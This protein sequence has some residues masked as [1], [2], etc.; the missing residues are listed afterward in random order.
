MMTPP[1]GYLRTNP[2]DISNGWKDQDR[3]VLEYQGIFMHFQFQTKAGEVIGQ[4]WPIHGAHH[5]LQLMGFHGA[6]GWGRV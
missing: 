2:V 6:K 5:W 3:W 1:A 4:Y